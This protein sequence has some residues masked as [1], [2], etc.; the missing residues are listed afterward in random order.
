MAMNVRAVLRY[1]WLMMTLYI[2]GEI[3]DSAIDLAAL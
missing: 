2:T 1:G 3:A